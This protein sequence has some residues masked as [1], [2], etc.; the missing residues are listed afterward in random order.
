MWSPSRQVWI[1][2]GRMQLGEMEQEADGV[3]S[4]MQEA[5]RLLEAAPSEPVRV[6]THGTNLQSLRLLLVA[7]G[8]VRVYQPG[9]QMRV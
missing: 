1:W 8:V 9:Q 7:A 4:N 3:I 6:D 2:D 5:A